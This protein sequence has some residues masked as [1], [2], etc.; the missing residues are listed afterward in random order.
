[1]QAGL[2]LVPTHRLLTKAKEQAQ[3]GYTAQD[4]GSL[5]HLSLELIWKALKNSDNLNALNE[6]QVQT[7]VEDSIDTCFRELFSHAN[8]G[9]NT[10][11]TVLT[12]LEKQRM[13]K[14]SSV[15][16]A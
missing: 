1:M 14:F 9:A 12:G 10:F 16:A 13:G 2:H 7:I 5:V 6:G 8:A 11:G 4:R 15:K 3:P